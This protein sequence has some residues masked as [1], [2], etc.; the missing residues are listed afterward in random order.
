MR[1]LLIA[2]HAPVPAVNGGNQRTNLLYRALAQAARVDLLILSDPESD[3]TVA[4][5]LV[6][7]FG[8]VAARPVPPAPS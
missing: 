3:P 7:D 1:L 8:L 5:T 4:A 6:Q 2:R